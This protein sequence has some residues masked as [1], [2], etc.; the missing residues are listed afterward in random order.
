MDFNAVT[1]ASLHICC[2]Y[3]TVLLITFGNELKEDVCCVRV[4]GHVAY[5]IDNQH[6]IFCKE[7]Q[8]RFQ[9]VFLVS[10]FKLHD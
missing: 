5:F 10:F 3:G 9:P 8:S 7:L 4:D 1:T 2:D 6:F